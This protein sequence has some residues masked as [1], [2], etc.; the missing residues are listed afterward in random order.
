[1][2]YVL[3]SAESVC[4]GHPD[5]ISDLIAD[6]IVTQALKEDPESRVGVEVQCSTNQVSLAGEV[7]TSAN[8]NYEEIVKEALTR[9]GYYGEEGLRISFAAETVKVL[10]NI[11][12]QSPDI[13]QGVDRE[14]GSLGA[15]DQ[16]YMVGVATS[17]EGRDNLMPAAIDL[18]HIL[19]K[20]MDD[21]RPLAKEKGILLGSDGKCFI[22]IRQ[23]VDTMKVDSVEMIVVAQSHNP[24]SSQEDVKEFIWE[25]VIDPFLAEE[26]LSQSESFQYICNGTGKFEFYGPAADAGVTGRKL[27]VDQYGVHTPIG[28]GALTGKDPSKVDRSGA[29]MA[30][31]LA[32]EIVKKDL[33]SEAQV[34]LSYAI[35]KPDPL[36]VEVTTKNLKV[37]Q[38]ALDR[39]I[40]EN[41]DFSVSGIIERF[42]LKY[43]DYTVLV[44]P[45]QMG[46]DPSLSPWEA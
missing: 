25:F 35:G 24:S 40:L 5:R 4:A 23:D 27:V 36:S 30:R 28:G 16:G 19:S 34:V 20:R 2:T 22:V 29:Y 17:L 7:T 31:F 45:G 32:K 33:A 41:F 37:S 11:V 9:L 46:Q 15:G 18:A 44:T 1:M 39:W 6:M 26:R 10:N 42:K 13:A 14:E 43:Q 8:L 21:I 12:Q 3:K 38:E